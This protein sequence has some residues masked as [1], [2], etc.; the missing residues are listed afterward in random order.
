MI[1]G[2]KKA[3]SLFQKGMNPYGKKI[4]EDDSAWKPIGNN[5]KYIKE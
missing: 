3:F 5:V 4:E 1:H 2:F